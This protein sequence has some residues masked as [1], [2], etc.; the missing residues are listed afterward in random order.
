MTREEAVKRLKERIDRQALLLDDEDMAALTE[1]VPELAESE[2]ERI[3]KGLIE[4]LKTSKTVGELKFILPEPTRK[5]CIAYL[6]KQKEQKPIQEKLSYEELVRNAEEEV[7]VLYPNN[8][9]EGTEAWYRRECLRE[10][11]MKGAVRAAMEILD[12]KEQKKQKPQYIYLKFREG[13][14]IQKITG[15]RDIVTIAEVNTDAEEYRLTNS[16]FIPFKY[17]HL[18][19]LI[20]QK[21]AEWS[22]PYGENETVDRL[23]SIAECLEMDG[24]CLFNGYSG[25]ECGKFLRDLARKQIECKPAECIKTEELAEHIKAEFESFRNLL[26]K[27]GIDYQPAEAYWTDFARLFV[28]SAKKLQKPAEWSEE[29]KMMIKCCQAAVTFYQDHPQPNVNGVLLPAKFNIGGYLASPDKVKSWLK[30]LPER[31]NL[32]PKREWSDEDEKMLK[33]IVYD[34]AAGHKSSIGQDK[35]LKSLRPKS[36]WKPS[37]EQMDILDKVYHYLWADKNATADMQDGL[38]DFIDEIKKLK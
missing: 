19:Y 7:N 3:R 34:F 35:W 17:E 36:Q 24:D 32:R 15:D 25:T 11:Y 30:S 37:E 9:E 23:V 16:G 1:L 6:E 5:E 13:D 33:S 4:A 26:K 2:D 14:T 18:W 38:G 27:K 20:E 28:S 21:P 31:F 12:I 8:E 29:D 22:Y 10:H